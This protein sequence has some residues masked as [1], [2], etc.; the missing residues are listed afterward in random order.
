MNRVIPSAVGCPDEPVSKKEAYLDW[1]KDFDEFPETKNTGLMLCYCDKETSIF[2]P[3]TLIG[4][5]FK[6]FSKYNPTKDLDNR[7]YCW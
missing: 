1:M 6:E 7:N 2:L 3:W 4:K 5:N